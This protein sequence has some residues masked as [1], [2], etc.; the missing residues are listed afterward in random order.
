MIRVGLIGTG[1]VARYHAQAYQRLEGATLA[2]V[3]DQD[4]SKA[5]SFARRYS[6][7]A[8]PLVADLLTSEVEVVDICTPT[9][10]H[11]DLAVR[12]M[13]LGKHVLCEK[14]I[15]RTLDE[16]EA[17]VEAAHKAG[18]KFMVA[19]VSR[20]EADHRLAK[21]V[22][23]RGDIGQPRMGWQA[24]VGPFPGWSSE[25]WFADFAASGGPLLD[26]AIHSFDYLNW[27]FGSQVR[28]IY[29]LGI[30][31]RIHLETHTLSLLRYEDGGMA[32][33]EAS[34]AMPTGSPLLVRTEL[35]GEAGVIRWDSQSTMSLRLMKEGGAHQDFVPV[36]EDGFT[37]EIR[38]FLECVRDGKPPLVSGEEAIAALR[39]SLA[40]IESMTTRRPVTLL[41]DAQG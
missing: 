26:L 34:W 37:A 40:A 9:P 14:P 32:L 23:E 39:V 17:M 41:P 18:V 10:T 21:E 3:A 29:A 12:A 31:Q 25:G 36:A 11:K 1:W 33:V 4:Y 5:Q 19:H 35:V 16:A 6:A 15:A 20:F 24:I 7:V 28:S 27:I 2:G 8:H 13:G 30:R 22:I 38:H